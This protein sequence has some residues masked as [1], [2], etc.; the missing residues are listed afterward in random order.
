VQLHIDEPLQYF[1]SFDWN[2]TQ[3][4]KDIEDPFDL[5][6]TMDQNNTTAMSIPTAVKY[7]LFPVKRN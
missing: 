4:G 3:T 6:Q 1:F 7:Q 5:N 2:S